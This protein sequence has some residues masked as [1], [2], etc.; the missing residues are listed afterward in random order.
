MSRLASDEGGVADARCAPQEQNHSLRTF[1]YVF[2]DD[3]VINSTVDTNISMPFYGAGV[4]DSGPCTDDV[5]F[6][7]ASCILT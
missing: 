4:C 1:Y 7:E 2:D 6:I 5:G 3:A